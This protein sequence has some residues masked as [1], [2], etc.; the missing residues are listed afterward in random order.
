[1]ASPPDPTFTHRDAMQVRHF[2]DSATSTLTYVVFDPA[3]KVGVVIDPVLDYDPRSARL[4]NES[5][6]RV[7]AFI[8]E[9]GLSIPYV[10]DTHV[11]AY[12]FSGMAFFRERYGA[13]GV[14]GARITEVQAVFR[15]LYGLGPDFPVDG[16]QWDLLMADGD[17][18]DVGPFTIVNHNTPGHT[19]AC[20]TWQ[21]GEKLF[22]GDVIFMPDFGTARCDFPNG[23]AELLYDSIT[24]KLYTF[25]DHYEIY[26]CHDYQP[27]GRELEFRSTVGQQKASNKQLRGDTPREDY[28]RW[29]SERDAT[30]S[31]PALMLAALQVNIR[32]GALPEPDANG[33]SYLRLP[34]NQF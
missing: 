28:V 19:P 10:L 13:R 4:H 5:S 17:E 9:Q 23:S 18:L 12:H 32:A 22:V 6:E 20:S 3:S 31:L 8:D 34:L 2:F 24:N 33:V 14:I 26:T 7:A 11:H 16:S 1:M 15:D 30:L 27:G 25:P 21:I 29:R